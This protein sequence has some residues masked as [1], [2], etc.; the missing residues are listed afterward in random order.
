MSFDEFEEW[1]KKQRPEHQHILNEYEEFQSREYKRNSELMEKHLEKYARI[2]ECPS[3]GAPT[4][5]VQPTDTEG[6]ELFIP[7]LTCIY[8]GIR[9]KFKNNKPIIEPIIVEREEP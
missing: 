1:I 3:C 7:C 2:S 8:N 4:F 9:V 6:L 5:W